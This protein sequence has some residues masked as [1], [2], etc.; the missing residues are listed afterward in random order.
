LR[1]VAPPE[2]LQRSGIIAWDFDDLPAC[3]TR[4]VHGSEVSAYPALVERDGAVAIDLFESAPA[5]ERA[6][7]AGVRRLLQ[8]ACK[9][10]LATLDKRMP[11]PVARRYGLPASKAEQAAFAE[12]VRARLTSEAFA[13]G[14]GGELP[15]TRADFQR[16]LA[17]GMPRL[18]PTFE[19]LL[20]LL[21][22]LRAELEQTMRAL[23]AAKDQPSAGQASAD[24]RAQLE[25]LLPADLL[26]HT[27]LA[28][29][30]HFPRYLSAARARLARAIHDPR[31]DVSK[32]EPIAALLRAFAAKYPQAG[33]R[34]AAR[35]VLLSLEELRV[36][37]FAPEL[38]PHKPPSVA[39]ALREVAEL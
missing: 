31:K 7:E 26:H 35:R 4:R 17:Q 33:D 9:G 27:T 38:R 1:Q 2:H 18:M 5:A 8:L 19:A 15:R 22:D 6:H 21:G 36:V 20:K 16:L 30:A 37:T 25:L 14:A 23:D 10:A 39:D 3:V 28:Q 24:I 11:P 13:L 12:S 29:L 32:A 34:A